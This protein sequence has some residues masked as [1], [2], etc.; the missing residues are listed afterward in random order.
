M[1]ARGFLALFGGSEAASVNPRD[2]YWHSEAAW[3]AD[4]VKSSKARRFD[5]L[6]S[7]EPPSAARPRAARSFDSALGIGD[8]VVR[9]IPFVECSAAPHS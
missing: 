5:D 2:V 9:T 4:R 8:K 1:P 6:D 7:T 3:Y